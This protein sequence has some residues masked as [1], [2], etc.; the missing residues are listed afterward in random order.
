[1]HRVRSG[2]RARYYNQAPDRYY[3]RGHGRAY[4]INDVGILIR[5][6]GLGFSEWKLNLGNYFETRL[7]VFSVCGLSAV[8]CSHAN[9]QHVNAF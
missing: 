8:V 2:A 5:G 3:V 7:K 6:G 1:M 4:D 9:V